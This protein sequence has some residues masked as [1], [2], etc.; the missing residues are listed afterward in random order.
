[1]IRALKGRSR[2]LPFGVWC[3]TSTPVSGHSWLRLKRGLRL[4]KQNWAWAHSKFGNIWCRHVACGN[5]NSA[6]TYLPCSLAMSLDVLGPFGTDI[7]GFT[8]TVFPTWC[9]SEIIW[10]LMGIR[11]DSSAYDI[12]ILTIKSS[13]FLTGSSRFESSVEPDYVWR[14][15]ADN[16]LVNQETP[17]TCFNVLKGQADACSFIG[18]IIEQCEFENFRQIAWTAR[19]V[20]VHVARKSAVRQRWRKFYIW[21]VHDDRNN[22]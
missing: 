5:V 17:R 9:R 21:G 20:N 13:E 19:G 14:S 6:L 16:L 12:S 3:S 11:D 7:L 1:M 22:L 15:D 8:L 2:I 10:L 4:M 18:I